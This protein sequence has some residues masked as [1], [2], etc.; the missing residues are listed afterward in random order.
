MQELR[1]TP[2]LQCLADLVPRGAALAD[3]GTDHAH[4]P[5]YLLQKGAVRYAVASDLREGPLS[6]AREN[7]K[8]S[9]LAD[10]IDLRLAPG[11]DATRAEE[12]DTVA[13]AGMGGET[14]ATI[15]EAAPWTADGAHTLLLQPM[16]RIYELRRFLYCGGYEIET[17]R[18]CREGRR[19]YAVLRARGTGM[20]GRQLLLEECTTSPALLRDPHARDY[21]AALLQ[22][23]RRA[24]AGMERGAAGGEERAQQARIVQTLEHAWEELK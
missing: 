10:R 23:E 13:I 12:C 8:A 4:L 20:P 2:R 5:L 19:F 16:T 7:A 9:G 24:L 22:R 6:R 11:L 21:L 15:L 14:I 1:L 18:V 3:V 17:E